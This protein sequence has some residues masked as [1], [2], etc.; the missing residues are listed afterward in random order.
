MR[1]TVVTK[2]CRH[3]REALEV[4]GTV[5]TGRA[6]HLGVNQGVAVRNRR[7]D[8]AVGHELEHRGIE[9]ARRQRTQTVEPEPRAVDSLFA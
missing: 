5:G 4:R 3:Q 1:E 6:R 9:P 8:L 7:F 2:F